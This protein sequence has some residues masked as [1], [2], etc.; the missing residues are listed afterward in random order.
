M[1]WINDGIVKNPRVA[2]WFSKE[3]IIP[4]CD[5]CER[6]VRK[7]GSKP[8]LAGCDDMLCQDCWYA[9][10]DM[11]I[12]DKK[13]LKAYVIDKHGMTGGAANLGDGV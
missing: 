8:I 3:A 10:Y 11:N 2:C 4:I 9:W 5:C 12:T 7:K 13:A 6:S 1:K